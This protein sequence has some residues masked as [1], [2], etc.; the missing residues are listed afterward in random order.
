MA[1]LAAAAV[2]V[3]VPLLPGPPGGIVRS[4]TARLIAATQV[5]LAIALVIDGV[6]GV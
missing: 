4:S 6:R 3:A 2:I 5:V 1:A